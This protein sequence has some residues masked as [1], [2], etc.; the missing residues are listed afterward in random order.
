M[1]ALVVVV[2]GSGERTSAVDR[3]VKESERIEKSS[4]PEQVTAH[5]RY[6]STPMD[7]SVVTDH[8]HTYYVVCVYAM[9]RREN[10][11]KTRENTFSIIR[12][13]LFFLSRPPTTETRS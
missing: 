6:Y 1:F 5:P 7:S 4:E 10:N 3:L 9:L 13:L 2:G 12:K 8:A 11:A